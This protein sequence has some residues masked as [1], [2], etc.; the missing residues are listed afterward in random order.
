[1]PRKTTALDTKFVE[2]VLTLP[3]ARCALPPSADP[4]QAPDGA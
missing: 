1:M 3:D 2:S 4:A